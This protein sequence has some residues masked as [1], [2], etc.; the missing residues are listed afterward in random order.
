MNWKTGDIC[1]SILSIQLQLKEKRNKK[2]EFLWKNEI[3]NGRV[4]WFE[5]TAYRAWYDGKEQR[6][7]LIRSNLISDRLS[8]VDTEGFVSERSERENNME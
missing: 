2:N 8:D 5:P 7:T 3:H 1:S 6:K 4:E